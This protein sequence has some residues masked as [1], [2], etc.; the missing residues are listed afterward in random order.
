M[1][2]N[3]NTDRLIILNYPPGAGGKFIS[4]C[5]A[6]DPAVLHQEK[7]LAKI[8]IAG[9]M[10]KERS[11]KWSKSILTKSQISHFE[12]G[13]GQLAGFSSGDK[14][15]EQSRL[16]N[17][18][19]REITNQTKFYFLMVDHTGGKWTHYPNSQHI[20]IK[21][22][23]WITEARQMYDKKIKEEFLKK[24]NIV[25]FDQSSIKDRIS[26]KEEIRKLFE[27]FLLDEPNWDHIEELR[28]AWLDTF[29]IG[30]NDYKIKQDAKKSKLIVD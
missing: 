29:R 3:Y 16:A 28:F 10:N 6:L 19:W 5:L 24:K 1:D 9:R 18:L 12:L 17:D 20:I 25:Y 11:F 8:K 21:N 30:F 2:I 15:E 4:L 7:R 26:F 13:C 14:R 22:Y 23:E 27:C